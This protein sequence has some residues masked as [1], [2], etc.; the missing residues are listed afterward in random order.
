MKRCLTCNELN[1]ENQG[2]CSNCGASKFEKSISVICPK[3]SEIMDATFF[4]CIE[5]GTRLADDKNNIGRTIF[6]N[7]NEVACPHC[8]SQISVLSV[9]CPSCGKNIGN[10]TMRRKIKKLVCPNCETP[11][12]FGSLF[13]S[14][15]FF[16]LTSAKEK[17]L[18][19]VLKPKQSGNVTLMQCI[20]IGEGENQGRVLCPNCQAFNTDDKDYCIKCGQRLIL[21]LPK[22]YCALCGA[23]NTQDASYCMA[24]QHSFVSKKPVNE[25]YGW[26]CSCAFLNDEDNDY[27]IA[28]GKKSIDKKVIG[29]NHR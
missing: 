19:V 29:R 12:D 20:L 27:C 8:G 6:E 18:N 9:Y 23:E 16:G 26:T 21:E 22:K 28:C 1:S 24:C 7:S 13:C 14:Y 15:C 3:C 4:Y 10:S 5:C 11:N 2:F 17:E 25:N